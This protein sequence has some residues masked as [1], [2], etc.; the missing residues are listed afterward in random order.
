MQANLYFSNSF[1]WLN[2][3][4]F[5]TVQV[6]ICPLGA[7]LCSKDTHF[8]ALR[9]HSAREANLSRGVF[10]WEPRRFHRGI[11]RPIPCKGIQDHPD[12]TFIII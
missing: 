6:S 11:A 4:H 10:I 3:Q 7:I 1:A 9:A 12:K 8:W 5:F 2:L